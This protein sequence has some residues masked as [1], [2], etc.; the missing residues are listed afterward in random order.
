MPIGSHG[1]GRPVGALADDRPY[2]AQACFQARLQWPALRVSARRPDLAGVAPPGHTVLVHEALAQRHGLA[3]PIDGLAA[4]PVHGIE[5]EVFGR[6]DLRPEPRRHGLPLPR[7]HGFDLV[8]PFLRVRF[9][10][11]RRQRPVD[12]GGRFVQPQLDHRQVGR[13]G[14][15][16]IRQRR[17]RD[18]DLR[19]IELFEIAAEVQQQQVAFVAEQRVDGALAALVRPLHRAQ[20]LNRFPEDIGAAFGRDGAPS[21]PA[22]A[23]HLVQRA[24]ALHGKRHGRSGDCGNGI[25]SHGGRSYRLSAVSDRQEPTA[26]GCIYIIRAEAGLLQRFNR[27]S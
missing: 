13:S 16:V 25:G 1:W 6:G 20:Q 17:A 9:H 24:C 19:P 18:F 2:R 23:H 14:L 15:Q 21:G 12:L 8:V 22:E 26:G 5:A 27:R 10:A 11:A 3:I 7:Q 4:P